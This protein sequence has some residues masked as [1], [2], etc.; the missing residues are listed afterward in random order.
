MKKFLISNLQFPNIERGFTILYSVLVAALLLSIGLSIY[1]ISI[2]QFILTS[3]AID[4]QIAIY[5]ADAGVECALHWDLLK[6]PFPEP[7]KNENNDD[8]IRQ[9]ITS[10][11]CN[12]DVIDLSPTLGDVDEDGVT[13]VV[14]VFKTN[15]NL[16]DP[17]PG[18][19]GSDFQCAEV[20]VKKEYMDSDPTAV[21]TKI[22]SRGYNYC[23]ENPRR[24]E[25][26]LR[27]YYPVGEDEVPVG[28]D[29]PPPPEESP[30]PSST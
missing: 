30:S 11:N 22:E 12:E 21:K 3:S 9:D 4:S 8:I 2:K 20:T 10:I 23:N 6:G 24:V 16:L 1:N 14:T 26:A 27:V 7:T 5:A 15:F 28:S 25:R 29:E 19:Y 17:S 18:P 13:D